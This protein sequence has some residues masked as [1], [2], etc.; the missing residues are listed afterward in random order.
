MRLHFMPS[1]VTSPTL[2]ATLTL[3]LTLML[4]A[5]AAHAHIGLSDP[6]ARYDDQKAGACGR[7][8][9][10]DGRTATF[11]RYQPGETITVRWNEEIDHEGSFEVQFD[12]D[13]ADE[14]DFNNTILTQLADPRGGRN[15]W[16]AEVTLPDVECTNCTLR[17]V[18]IMTTSPN[19]GAGD[20]YYQCAD[21]VLGDGE[22]AE[23][24]VSC[25]AGQPLPLVSMLLG[26]FLLRGRRAL[27][28]RGSR[29]QNP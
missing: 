19:P 9:G 25:A 8:A 16:D 1:A 2:T 26:L 21:V 18:Q 7:G 5:T 12:D 10:Q 20:F 4:T 29:S 24:S 13:G 14:A 3:T 11:T 17:L 22:S 27:V 15:D 6:P 23:A 28:T